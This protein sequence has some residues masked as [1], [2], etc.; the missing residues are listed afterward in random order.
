MYQAVDG[1]EDKQLTTNTTQS[2]ISATCTERTLI[3]VVLILDQA[4]SYLNI[5]NC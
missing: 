5:N 1:N 4:V 2:N 3:T